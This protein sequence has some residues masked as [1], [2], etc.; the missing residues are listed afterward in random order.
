MNK[1][2]FADDDGVNDYLDSAPDWGEAWQP[3]TGPPART[4]SRTALPVERFNEIEPVLSGLW[5]IKRILPSQGLAL[6]YGHPGSGKSFFA[7]DMAFHI[8]LGWDW[9]GR[10][11]K[12]GAVIYVG[13]EGVNG[14]RNRMVAFR[15]HHQ[16]DEAVPITLVPCPINLQD[17]EADVSRLVDTIRA[18]IEHHGF[19]AALIV[20]DTLS[21]TFGAGKEN[22][23]DM[24]TYVA[25]CDRVATEFRCC[26]M[27]VHHRPK[28]AES[29][30]PRGHSSLR[31]GV[32][33]II[34]I[35]SGRTK[36]AEV[37]KQKDGED[38]ERFLFNLRP[39]ELG[40]DEDG[41][42]V[43]SCVVQATDR[44]LTPSADPFA[45][46]VGR[47][48]TKNR[49]AYDQLGEAIEQSGQ[50]LPIEIPDTE[51]D[52]NRVGKV[53]EFERWR[54]KS[55]SA[56]GTEAG[57]SRDTAKRTFNRSVEKLQSEGIVRVWNQWAWITH[58]IA[59]T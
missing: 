6:I 12:Q 2:M 43:T 3:E 4:P 17:P 22:T 15:L 21:K 16:I 38:N 56:A 28:D 52:R 40:E 20:I 25:N 50:P 47:L 30:E 53:V 44:D 48:S 46:A 9:Q 8:A 24:A 7:L 54:D 23:D 34:L 57:Q 5:L 55:I 49:L 59:G 58:H 51:I 27:P 29:T 31:G 41:E 36:R 45:K 1:G 39:I 11:V 18:E 13:A 42:P 32:D 26:V 14:L 35:E 19:D 37:K 10:K 33:T